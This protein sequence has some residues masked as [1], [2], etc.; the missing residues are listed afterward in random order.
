MN[1]INIL[2]KVLL[3]VFLINIMGISY[4]YAYASDVSIDS[5]I[6]EGKSFIK[7][8][9]EAKTSLGD[10]IEVVNNATNFKIILKNIYIAFFVIGIVATVIISGILG[11]KIMIGSVEEK[12]KAKELLVPYI[13]GCTVIFGS[14]T[15]WKIAMIIAG[16][17]S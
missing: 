17:I 16:N 10:P 14:Y 13:I 7:T 3:V 5:T 8:G 9:K 1:K 15:I 11:I 12:A 2:I 6:K 4:N